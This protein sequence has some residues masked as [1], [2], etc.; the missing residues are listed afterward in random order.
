MRAPLLITATAL[1]LSACSTLVHPAAD[2]PAFRFETQN[3]G[4]NP[5]PP[6]TAEFGQ[7]PEAPISPGAAQDPQPGQQPD[8]TP[9][10]T[11]ESGVDE[12]VEQP[13][14]PYSVV[15]GRGRP[16]PASRPLRIRQADTL[17]EGDRYSSFRFELNPDD[18]AAYANF[19]YG[20][21]DDTTIDVLIGTGQQFETIS[22]AQDPG[23]LLDFGVQHR[24]LSTDSGVILSGRLD[25]VLSDDRS[26][27]AFALPES[28][29]VSG[30][31]K[32]ISFQPQVLMQMP[33]GNSGAHLYASSGLRLGDKTEPAI[34]IGS[35]V[36][37]PVGRVDLV[38]ELDWLYQGVDGVPDASE[39]YLTPGIVF[40]VREKL[41]VSIGTAIGLSST[42]EDWRA[43]IT[44]GV[45]F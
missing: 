27:E 34:T 45:R 7:D 18:S 16:L 43:M 22:S 5:P 6:P 38:T 41:D 33:I 4:G 37:V 23:T 30:Q 15:P 8:V 29:N 17:G 24:F 19:A 32:R 2:A 11:N 35:G 31:S 21:F 1:A 40:P 3:P 12:V 26:F 20:L 28:V 25:V 36:R 14:E 13:P 44:M 39:G 10:S 42:S 9:P